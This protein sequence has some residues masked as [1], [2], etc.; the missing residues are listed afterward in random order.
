M[1]A[2]LSVIKAISL[3]PSQLKTRQLLFVTRHGNKNIIIPAGRQFHTSN[4]H[5]QQQAPKGQQQASH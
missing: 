2:T 4:T 5:W 1:R 3:P